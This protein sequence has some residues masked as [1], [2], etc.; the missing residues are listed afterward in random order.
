MFSVAAWRRIWFKSLK[1]VAP[2]GP[3]A[4][5]ASRIWIMSCRLID[6]SASSFATRA[7]KAGSCKFAGLARM[8]TVVAPASEPL[9]AVTVQVPAALGAVNIPLPLIVPP[10]V[11]QVNTCGLAIGWPNWSKASGV[12]CCVAPARTAGALGASTILVNV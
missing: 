5:T 9:W 4:A 8:V 2:S 1:S 12:N 7:A 11:L 10:L 6:P 3:L